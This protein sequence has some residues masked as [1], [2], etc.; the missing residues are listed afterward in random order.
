MISFQKNDMNPVKPQFSVIIPS[1]NCE[2]TITTCL[3]S[4]NKQTYQNFEIVIVD[5][6]STDQSLDTINSFKT[7]ACFKVITQKNSGA[8]AARNTGIEK[9]IGNFLVF[10]DSDDYLDCDFLQKTNEMIESTNAEIVFIDI[11]R[12]D[13]HGN[14]LRMEKLSSFSKLDKQLFLR[15]Q[16]TGK[17]PW[18][19][20]R[21]IVKS[22]LVKEHCIRYATIHVGEECIYSFRVLEN[23]K[24]IAFLESSYYHYVVSTS[25][26]TANDKPENTVQVFANIVDY[27]T[28]SGKLDSYKTTINA[29]AVTSIVIIINVLA[30]Q[31]NFIK[32][33]LESKKY[34]KKYKSYI[35]QKVDIDALEFRVRACL[36]FLK[37]GIVTPI[38][39]AAY[40]KRLLKQGKIYG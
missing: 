18:G 16:L 7:N 28:S 21:K 9:S 24:K 31:N 2:K 12:E 22:D 14:I 20:V 25:S 19:G 23:A 11:I 8:G 4:L 1:Y 33:L 6:G 32:V 30:Q 13:E 36:P 5:D 10:L 34:Y 26:L 27:F 39:V 15:Q 38:V 29:M 17:I 35:K 37:I 3:G 40:L